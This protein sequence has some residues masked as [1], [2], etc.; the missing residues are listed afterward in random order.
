MKL[1]RRAGLTALNLGLLAAVAYLALD[2]PDAPAEV[3]W[4]APPV[5]LPWAPPAWFPEEGA[6]E[7]WT[8]QDLDGEGGLTGRAPPMRARSAILA[9]LDRGEVLWSHNA[10]DLYPVASLTKMVSSLALMSAQPDLDAELCVDQEQWPSRS[11]ARSHF[12]TGTCHEGWEYLGAAL[13]S[14]DN[15]GAMAFPALAGLEYY[16]FIDRMYEVSSE[17]G[18]ENA[19]WSDP[20]GLE[21]DNMASARDM[22]RA[23]VAVSAHPVLSEV[24]TSPFWQIDRQRGKRRLGT[25]NRLLPRWEMLSVKTGYTDTAPYCFA[26]VGRTRSGRRLGVVV[27]GDRSVQGRFDTAWRLVRWA[28]QQEETLDG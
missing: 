1:L 2:V 10:D 14:S 15:R 20:S 9:D 28:E 3:S 13:V 18:L 12:E 19:T 16:D 11:G 25:T 21:D 27:L 24:A 23:V 4:T 17:L 22:L 8:L 7:L 5:D 6:D 26:T